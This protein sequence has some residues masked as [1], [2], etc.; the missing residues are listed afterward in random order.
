MASPR[1]VFTMH[2]SSRLD[3]LWGAAAREKAR[4][5]GFEV[6][7]NPGQPPFDSAY[8]AAFFEGADA[9]LASWGAPRLDEQVLAKCPRLQ[10]VGYAAGSVAGL[11]TPHLFERGVRVSTANREMARSVARWTLMMTMAGLRGLLHYAQIGAARPLEAKNQ[12]RIR[13]PHEC[14]IGIWGF[15]DVARAYIELLKAVLQ[16]REILVADE[17]MSEEMARQ[18][19]VAK[20]SFGEIFSRSDAIALL[21]S[22]TPESRGAVGAEQLRAIRDDA[23]LI[24]A[25]RAHL[26][27]EDAL[28]AELARNRFTG[29][30]DVYH[31]EPLPPDN[32]LRAMPNV[33]LTPHCAGSETRS[34]YVP[35]MLEE[36]DRLRRGQ[37]LEYEVSLE[38]ALAMTSLKPKGAHTVAV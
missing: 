6:V 20:V 7:V 25:G 17:Y 5:L 4:Q 19:G 14:A 18:T 30:F 13:N 22:L 24:N 29:I 10:F 36:Y 35:L 37:P 28:Y 8:W 9:I 12:G 38:R 16:P 21:Q 26:V 33:I 2:A 27:Q 23:V 1:I 32:P 15:G 31:T 3:E 34:L 11:V